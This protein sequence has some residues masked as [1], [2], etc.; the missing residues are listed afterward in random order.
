MHVV[1]L[2]FMANLMLETMFVYLLDISKGVDEFCV[3]MGI[4][5]M[6]EN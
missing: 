4:K 3:N 5:V 6:W 1:V 2:L